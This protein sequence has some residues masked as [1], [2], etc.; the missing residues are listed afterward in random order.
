[1]YAW[2]CEL[3]LGVWDSEGVADMAEVRR[4]VMPRRVARTAKG[5]MIRAEEAGVV[6][7]V[8]RSKKA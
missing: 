5:M 3:L 2:G 7:G 4:A 6:Q 1:M 8:E